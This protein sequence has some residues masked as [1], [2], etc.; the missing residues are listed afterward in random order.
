L[1]PPQNEETAAAIRIARIRMCAIDSI[2]TADSPYPFV[3]D[4]LNDTVGR[5]S[6]RVWL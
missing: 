6:T 5:T 1:L 3:S 4:A 2:E